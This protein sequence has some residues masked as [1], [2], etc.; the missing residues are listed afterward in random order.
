MFLESIPFFYAPPSLPIVIGT[1][2]GGEGAPNKP[3]SLWKELYSFPPWGEIK[4]G[5]KYIYPGFYKIGFRFLLLRISVY[6]ASSLGE[7]CEDLFFSGQGKYQ[8]F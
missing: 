1:S 4:K 8:A 6:S 7:P 3:F 2:P 5:G